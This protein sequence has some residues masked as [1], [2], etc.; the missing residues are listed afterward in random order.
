M[1]K[2]L[3]FTVSKDDIDFSSTLHIANPSGYA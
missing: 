1:L 3:C 2:G